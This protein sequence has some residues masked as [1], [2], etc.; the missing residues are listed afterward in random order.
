MKH[1][2]IKITNE[3]NFVKIL[4]DAKKKVLTWANHK[5]GAMIC[6]QNRELFANYLYIRSI[7]ASDEICQYNLARLLDHFRYPPLQALL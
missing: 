6:L 3:S 1:K 2:L 4:E 5:C 7:S